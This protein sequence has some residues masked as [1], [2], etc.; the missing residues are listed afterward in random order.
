MKVLAPTR[1]NLKLHVD[2]AENVGRTQ[3]LKGA[4]SERLPHA[5]YVRISH[6]A[7]PEAGLGGFLR[8]A[9]GG[10]DDPRRPQSRFT[11]AEG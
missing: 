7:S 10:R 2:A 9:G 6:D 8:R 1:R 5:T 11:S 3:A 4:P